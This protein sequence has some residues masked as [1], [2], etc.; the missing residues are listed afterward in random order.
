MAKISASLS[1][2]QDAR[3]KSEI[4]LRFVGGRDHIY[5]L[6]SGLFV[7]PS[8]WKDGAVIVPRLETEEQRELR[9]VASRL[10]G[11]IAFILDRFGEADKDTVSR[12]WMQERIGEYHHPG[13]T[14]GADIYAL[15]DEFT[16]A[17]DVSERRMRRYKVAVEAL[18]RFETWRGRPMPVYGVGPEVLEELRDFLEDEYLLAGRRRWRTLYG[19]MG[20]MPEKRSDNTIVDYMKV[21][22]AFWRWMIG[23]GVTDV[24]PFVSYEIGTEVYGTPYYITIEERERLYKTN[25]KRHPSLAVQRDIFVFQCLVGCRVGD[26]VRIKKGDIVDGVLVYVP[27][28][29][30]RED[31]REV[32]VPLTETAKEIVRRYGEIRGDALL[33]FISPQKYNDA[34]K[35]FFLAARLTRPVSV[36]DPVSRREVKRPLNEVASSHLARRTFIGNLYRQVKDQ[37][38]VGAMS[39]HGDG[40]RAFARYRTIDDEIKAETVALLEAKSSGK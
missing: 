40:S 33:P 32:R 12:A 18:K 5:R 20:R 29:T 22:R 39:G 24:D 11:L 4:L 28:K 31:A 25:L 17:K 9:A 30:I 3:G 37:N 23:K 19:A 35:R 13:K 27:Q 15:F 36:L 2:R 38:I 16:R 7:S 14:A 6:H 34:I 26:L 21:Y 8:R 10:S 1:V